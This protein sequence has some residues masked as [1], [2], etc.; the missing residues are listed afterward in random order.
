MKGYT[1]VNSIDR[2]TSANVE[3]DDQAARLYVMER[4]DDALA[5]IKT[6]SWADAAVIG[7]P[8]CIY[9]DMPNGVRIVHD[10][11]S[12]LLGG[13]WGELFKSMDG[14]T[15]C[16]R[17]STYHNFLGYMLARYG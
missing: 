8:H 16:V 11:G 5:F 14:E 4:A 15:E 7:H 3:T 13:S 17:F 12:D 9:A 1:M 6:L 2:S 10:L